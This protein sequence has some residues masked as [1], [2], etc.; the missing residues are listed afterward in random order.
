MDDIREYTEQAEDEMIVTA[1][2]DAVYQKAND[3]LKAYIEEFENFFSNFVYKVKDLSRNKVD[4]VDELKY[5]KGDSFVNICATEELLDEL[6][7]YSLQKAQKE[8]TMLN[9][10]INGSIFD[11]VKNNAIFKMELEKSGEG[12][13]EED[14]RKNI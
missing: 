2:P 10:E 3:Y 12:Y 4:L 5:K 1:P 8:T 13:I 6:S 7:K 9:S 14:R 11:A